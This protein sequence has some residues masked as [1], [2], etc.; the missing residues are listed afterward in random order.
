MLVIDPEE[1]IDCG[2][3][4]SECPVKAIYSELDVPPAEA[5]FIALNADFFKGKSK[6]ELDR[7][8]ASG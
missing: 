6:E 8:R 4:I 5:S 2:L 3:C 7:A 1:C